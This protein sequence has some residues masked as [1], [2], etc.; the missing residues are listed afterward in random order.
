M[1]ED[2]RTTSVPI[3]R[4]RQDWHVW[5]RAIHDFGRAEGVWDLVRPDLEGE[6]AFRTEPAPITRP[7][8]GTDARTW[9]KYELDLAKQYKEFDQYDKEQDALRKFRYHLVCSVQHP[10]MTSLALEEHSHVIF[11]KLKERLCPTQSERRRDVRQRWKSLM[12][13]PPAKDVGI[14]LQ[15]WENT[16]ED[17]KEL[18]ILDEESAIDDLI[19]ANEQIDPI[20]R[21][22]SPSRQQVPEALQEEAASAQVQ[23]SSLPLEIPG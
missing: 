17:V 2:T 13:D 6:P 8:K 9:D 7:P 23:I 15:N 20:P 5:Y 1:D 4:S 18:G 11:K 21:H 16:Y 10:I 12:E 3:L 19:E 14:W 22:L